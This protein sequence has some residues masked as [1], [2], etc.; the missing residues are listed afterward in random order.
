MYNK[1]S[2]NL[3]Y[4]VNHSKQSQ[5]SQSLFAVIT[6]FTQNVALNSLGLAFNFHETLNSCTS[7]INTIFFTLYLT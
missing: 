1:R 2:G 4:G 3:L 7:K 6:H 5:G